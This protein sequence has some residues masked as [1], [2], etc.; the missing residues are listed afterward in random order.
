[1]LNS[2]RSVNYRRLL[3]HIRLAALT[4][5]AFFPRSLDHTSLTTAAATG[6][7]RPTPE[8]HPEGPQNPHHPH[9]TTK[10]IT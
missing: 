1:M 2:Q 9:S 4:A 8:G 3:Q 5:N 7:L 10:K 6:G